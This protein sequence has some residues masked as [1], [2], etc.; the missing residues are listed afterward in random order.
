MKI[1]VKFRKFGAL[2]FIGHLDMMRYFQKAL[3]RA[4]IDMK[5]SEGFNPHMILSFA[6]P[7]GVGI[8]SDGEYFDI[9]VLS[10]RS[11]EESLKALNQTMVEGVEVTSYVALPDNAKKSMSIVA[12]ADYEIYYK[13]GYEAPKTTE[14]FRQIYQSFYEEQDSIVILKKTKKSEKEMDI[15]PLIYEFQVRERERKPSFYLKVSTGSVDNLKPEL[16]LE[17]MYLFAGLEYRSEAMQIHKFETY[18]K[19][20]QGAFIPLDALGERIV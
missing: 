6:A 9:E 13:E 5:Y 14:E 12:A 7:L 10:T 2:K 20:E 17:Q 3:R 16:V 15:K 19:N 1:R 4:E 8:T 18:T 11:T